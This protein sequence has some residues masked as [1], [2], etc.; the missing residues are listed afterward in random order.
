MQPRGDHT[1]LDRR[2]APAR[3]AEAQLVEGARDV[4]A[5]V[6]ADEVA[7]LEGPHAK[8]AAEAA[9]AIDRLD[10]RDPFGER[11]QGLQAERAI[12]AVHQEPR[13]VG[14]A[15]HGLAHRAPGR[16]G[17]LKGAIRRAD[18]RDH[19]DELHQRRG[20]EEVHPHDALRVARGGGDARDR[21]GG[22]VGRQDALRRDDLRKSLVELALELGEL[23][24]GLDHQLAGREAVELFDDL[25]AL[26]RGL[27][28]LGG[29]PALR[30][31]LLQPRAHLLGT[32]LQRL[33]NRVVQQRPRPRAA[34]EL[35]DAGTHRAGTDHADRLCWSCRAH[36]SADLTCGRGAWAR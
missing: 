13:A 18:A 8:A 14:R 10:V 9:D 28:L 29:Q 4:E 33:S 25:Q 15:D 27:G 3:L 11:A 5:R 12:A 2:G 21:Q 1:R 16:V 19:L 17:E 30:G 24:R 7:E 20:V 34:R 26:R 31:F 6:H 22:R 36:P 23:G 35:R 32:A